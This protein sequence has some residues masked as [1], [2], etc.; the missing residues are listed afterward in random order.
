MTAFDEGRYD[1]FIFSSLVR[2][3]RMAA[4]RIGEY[5]HVT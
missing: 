5:E 2:E 1:H 3:E 4:Y